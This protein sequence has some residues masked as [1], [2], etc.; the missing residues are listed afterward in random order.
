[1]KCFLEIPSII[2]LWFC[3][4]KERKK[5]KGNERRKKRRKDQ[6]IKISRLLFSLSRIFEN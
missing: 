5:Y 2:K 4:K 1:M 6:D 3:K